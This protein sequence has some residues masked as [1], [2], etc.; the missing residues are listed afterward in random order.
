MGRLPRRLT[1]NNLPDL[2]DEFLQY[3]K[4]NGKRINSL[5][6]L[7]SAFKEWRKNKAA[8]EEASS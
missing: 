7:I 6:D 2:P 3:M 8:E 5:G 4:E 1:D